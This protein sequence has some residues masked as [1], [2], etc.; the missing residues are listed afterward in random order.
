MVVKL[1]HCLICLI[2]HNLFWSLK[3]Q[4]RNN[5]F[6]PIFSIMVGYNKFKSRFTTLK[7]ADD[8]SRATAKMGGMSI[9]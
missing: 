2:L 6:G 9:G 5:F 8:M 4:S 1:H 3:D 7:F